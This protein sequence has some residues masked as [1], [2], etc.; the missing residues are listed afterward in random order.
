MMTNPGGW[1]KPVASELN[2]P[3]NHFSYALTWF[4]LALGVFGVFISFAWPRLF[5]TDTRPV[6]EPSAASP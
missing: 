6:A 5:S 4:G 2:I 3:N 1:P